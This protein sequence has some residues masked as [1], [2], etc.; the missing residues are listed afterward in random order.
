MVQMDHILVM[1]I[2]LNFMELRIS[3]AFCS[4]Q[5]LKMVS[6]QNSPSIHL[7]WLPNASIQLGM[8]RRDPYQRGISFLVR[9]EQISA[10]PASSDQ[11]GAVLKLLVS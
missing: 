8:S 9:A 1:Q 3:Y 5:L 7:T 2:G 10:A 11:G 6:L 4:T